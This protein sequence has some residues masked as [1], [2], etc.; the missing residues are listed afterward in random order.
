MGINA[1][2]RVFKVSKNSIYRWMDRLANLK[3]ILFTYALCQ[4][5]IQQIIEGNELYS[6]DHDNKAPN[7][8]E[9]LVFRLVGASYPLRLRTTMRQKRRQ[10]I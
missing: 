7:E 5:F 2:C 8:S 10:S 6:K 3:Q 4:Q 9:G 1:T